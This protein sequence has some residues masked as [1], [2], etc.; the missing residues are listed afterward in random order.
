MLSVHKI[1]AADAAGAAKYY[2]GLGRE[3]YYENGGEPPGEWLGGGAEKLGLSGFVEAGQLGAIL[4][5][6][7]PSGAPISGNAGPDHAPGWDCTF[8]APKSVSAVWAA[9]SEED[10]QTIQ[11]AHKRAVAAAVGYLEKNAVFTRHGHAGADRQQI[12]SGIVAAAYEHS[13]SR[14]QDPQ[15]HTHVIVANMTPDGRGIDLDT[16]WKM[17]A[18]AVYRTHLAEHMK[19]AGFSIERDGK[20]FAVSG[21]PSQLVEQ[22]SSRREEILEAAAE[23]GVTSAKGMETA[24]LASRETKGEI[25]RPELFQAWS[26]QAAEHSFGPEQVHAL[27]D[28]ETPELEK[29]DAERI[30]G[31]LTQQYSTFS[32]AQLEAETY[33]QAQGAMSIAEAAALADEVERQAVAL[34][35]GRF[36][37]KEMLEIEQRMVDNAYAMHEARTHEVDPAHIERAIASRTLSGEQ[38][39]ALRHVTEKGNQIAL[40]QGWAGTGKTYMLDAAREVWEAQGYTV[41]G[42]ALAGKAAEG[43]QD[44]AKIPSQTLH[45]L[46]GEIE[47]AKEWGKPSPLDAKTVLVIDEAGMVGSRQM[48]YIIGEAEKVGAKVVKAGDSKQLPAIDAGGPFKAIGERIG[49]AEMK[50]VRRQK[51]AEDK[52]IAR[53]LREGR[54]GQALKMLEEKGRLHQAG[55]AQDVQRQAVANWRKDV[56]EGKDSIMLAGTRREV[57]SL[58]QQARAHMI[59]EG[60]VSR[61]GQRFET[62]QGSREFAQGDRVIFL[63][64]DNRLSVRNGTLGT[65]R[66]VNEGGRLT[67]SIKGKN[68]QERLVNVNTKGETGYSHIDHGYAATVHKSQGATV[69]RAHV[70]AGEMSGREWSYVAGSRNREEVHFYATTDQLKPLEREQG[71]GKDVERGG[72]ENSELARDMSRSAQKNIALDHLPKDQ[73]KDGELARAGERGQDREQAQGREGGRDTRTHADRQLDEAG[74]DRRT[75]EER[76]LDRLQEGRER[77]GIDKNA[78]DMRKE[79]YSPADERD[80]D[81]E[82]QAAIDRV[83][84][85]SQEREHTQERAQEMDLDR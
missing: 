48:A 78:G 41:K 42:A 55:K 70:I 5:G 43:L 2:E 64:N 44:D 26:E 10:R 32:R 60:R 16:R 17:A 7:H 63:K 61:D 40:I 21:V 22:W 81:A 85:K 66:G 76:Q 57:R 56:A 71:K 12:E 62:A 59:E 29:P 30:L 84:D 67:V 73:Q 46:I 72:V 34:E 13:T 24:A 53:H 75:H 47:R 1:R 39:E 11:A 37:T 50:D 65:V 14:N 38:Q 54:A 82:L 31:A 79:S 74:F 4:Q 52:V 69:D 9:G 23:H 3:D 25:N 27:K 19:E 51:S 18:G 45:S 80:L 8:S 35:G 58:N 6:F 28:L 33:T 49:Y 15:L 20:S 83:P 68:G 36:T 77:D